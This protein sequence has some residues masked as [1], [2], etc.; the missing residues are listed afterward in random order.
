M[1]IFICK[2]PASS[3]AIRAAATAKCVNRSWDLAVLAFVK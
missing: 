3:T 1:Y 2:V